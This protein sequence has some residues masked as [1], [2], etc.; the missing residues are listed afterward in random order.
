MAG[1]TSRGVY[2]KSKPPVSFY[3][4]SELRI[5][6][7]GSLYLFSLFGLFGRVFFCSLLA[8]ASTGRQS[9][10]TSQRKVSLS[11]LVFVPCEMTL[12]EL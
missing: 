6:L 11:Y 8:S 7:F 10:S 9:L 12:V 1:S 3:Q 4:G 5:G 2:A